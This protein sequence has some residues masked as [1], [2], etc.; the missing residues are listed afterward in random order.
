MD[1]NSGNLPQVDL[2][3]EG[4]QEGYEVGYARGL[5]D[6][7]DAINAAWRDKSAQVMLGGR[8]IEAPTA[9]QRTRER[10]ATIK[11]AHDAGVHGHSARGCP[12]CETRPRI[13]DVH[14]QPM[15]PGLV[16]PETGLPEWQC[17][18]SAMRHHNGDYGVPKSDTGVER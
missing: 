4:W 15:I 16:D 2:H 17:V 9:E 10:M 14:G 1:T 8:L 5:T 13:C 6:A 7:R 3:E 11:E 18:C 12:W